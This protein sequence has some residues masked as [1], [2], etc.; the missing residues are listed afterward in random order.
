MKKLVLVGLLLCIASLAPAVTL[1]WKAS[2]AAP[3]SWGKVSGDYGV[4]IIYGACADMNASTFKGLLTNAGSDVEGQRYN[5]YSVANPKDGFAVEVDGDGT[6]YARYNG[7]IDSLTGI[8]DTKGNSSVT[9]VVFN[10]VGMAQGGALTMVTVDNLSENA[11]VDLGTIDWKY[12]S[13][14]TTTSATVVPEPTVF[15]LLALG[16]AGFALRRK[17]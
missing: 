12:T 10:W 7:K 13:T 16:V 17:L 1:S 8:F 15:A 2:I 4:A 6:T 14:H 5:D 11:T 3:E 9:F